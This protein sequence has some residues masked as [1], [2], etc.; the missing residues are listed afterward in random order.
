MDMDTPIW[1]LYL[2]WSAYLLLSNKRM[3]EMT[4][5]ILPNNLSN[6]GSLVEI[7]FLLT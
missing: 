6:K 3:L 1:Q 2:I 5:P 4:R 7:A